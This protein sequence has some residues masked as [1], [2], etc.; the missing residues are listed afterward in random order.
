MYT[1]IELTDAT[2]VELQMAAKFADAAEQPKLQIMIE[3]T[4]LRERD[5]EALREYLVDRG[6][7]SLL[8]ETS[9]PQSATRSISFSS[10]LPL[11]H[12]ADVSNRGRAFLENLGFDEVTQLI[13]FGSAA[14]R[15]TVNH[16]FES[17]VEVLHRPHDLWRFELRD[18]QPNIVGRDGRYDDY[19]Y[20]V[21]SGGSA[22]GFVT[23]RRYSDDRNVSHIELHSIKN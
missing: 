5:R 2:D 19:K 7:R 4:D 3:R 8:V 1:A 22:I 11:T 16:S 9:R 10:V 17:T 12:S 21:Y 14:L 13:S 6:Y 15:Y 18:V 23:V 20:L